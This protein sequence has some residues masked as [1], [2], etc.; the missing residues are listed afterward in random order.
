VAVPEESPGLV[1][2]DVAGM[3]EVVAGGEVQPAGE[4]E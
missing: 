3:S 4:Q 1:G 2:E